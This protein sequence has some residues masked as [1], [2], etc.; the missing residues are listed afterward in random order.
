MS[1][2]TGALQP[3][4][5]QRPKYESRNLCH[6]GHVMYITR[7]SK[8]RQAT[9]QE[10]QVARYLCPDDS[11]LLAMYLIYVRPFAD[12]L[13]RKCH[14]RE[15]DR[16]LLFAAADQPHRPWGADVLTKALKSLTLDVCGAA[17]GVQVYRRVSIA[18]TER[19][20]KS[21]S[22]PFNRYDDKSPYADIE[23]AFAWQSGYRPMQRGIS[24]GIDAAYPDLLQPALLR[25]YKWA[26]TEWHRF[27]K[28]NHSLTSVACVQA[29]APD[30]R[31]PSLL[32]KR[33]RTQ[34]H[35]GQTPKRMRTSAE[36]Q[37]ASTTLYPQDRCRSHSPSSVHGV[38]GYNDTHFQHNID[39]SRT[40]DMHGVLGGI[41]DDVHYQ[42]VVDENSSPEPAF[43]LG[44]R[45][46][47]TE[48][49]DAGRDRRS[50]VSV[51][52]YGFRGTFVD[53]GD[54]IRCQALDIT[55]NGR[56]PTFVTCKDA[57]TALCRLP[58]TISAG[59]REL[60]SA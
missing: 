55:H 3:P 10:F 45:S 32:G 2:N 43:E 21:L 18:V 30:G 11:I 53:L 48:M 60:I 19:H 22:Q 46:V 40:Q 7:H 9:N 20:I 59:I 51:Q 57:V 41:A 26:S 56:V 49:N 38:A 6:D 17:F 27:L 42:S 37:S 52:A 33:A 35:D 54:L 23:V 25:V 36:H 16:R 34:D 24:Y 31:H 1:T 39:Q 13:H 15:Q 5:P 14:G 29:P 12:M 58:G 8:A 44:D 4:V 47:S 50:Y 28:L